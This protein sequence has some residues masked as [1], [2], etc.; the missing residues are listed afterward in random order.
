[1]ECLPLIFWPRNQKRI[2]CHTAKTGAISEGNSQ[3][4]PLMCVLNMEFM[5]IILM[6]VAERVDRHAQ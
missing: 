4:G 6:F 2:H 3:P 1:M 5:S